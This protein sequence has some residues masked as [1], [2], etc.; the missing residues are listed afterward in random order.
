MINKYHTNTNDQVECWIIESQ[1]QEIDVCN[2]ADEFGLMIAIKKD[3]PLGLY[4]EKDKTI[5]L[6]NPELSIFSFWIFLHELGHH[7]NTLQKDSRDIQALYSLEEKSSLIQKLDFFK[8]VTNVF[9]ISL[10]EVFQ[11]E[12]QNWNSLCNKY[13]EVSSR[14]ESISN[15]FYSPFGMPHAQFF[16]I[17]NPLRQEIETLSHEIKNLYYQFEID[18]YLRL[19]V[20]ISE[21]LAWSH[22]LNSIQEISDCFPAQILNTEFQYYRLDGSFS[23]MNLIQFMCKSLKSHKVETIF[24]INNQTSAIENISLSQ[25]LENLIS[26]SQS[27]FQDFIALTQER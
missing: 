11:E 19:P 1:N 6:Q 9:N 18:S 16:A 10:Q 4:S 26:E 25:E 22:A 14:L 15:R 12:N 24:T 23:N 3:T 20:A 8:K 17:A 2:L 13:F 21:L 5:Y 7:K 27:S